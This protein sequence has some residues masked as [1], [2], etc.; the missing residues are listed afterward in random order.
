MLRA[1]QSLR[2]VSPA[3]KVGAVPAAQPAAADSM[4]CFLT[5]EVGYIDMARITRAKVP[6]IMQAFAHTKGIVVDQRNYPGEP[7]PD[8]LPGLLL[9][10]PVVFAK[11]T[12]RDPTRV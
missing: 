12:Q 1:G 8:Y 3:S 9:A 5:P 2:L 10:Q 11:F 6:T 4:Y 7:V